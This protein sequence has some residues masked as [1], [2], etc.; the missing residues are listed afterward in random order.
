VRWGKKIFGASVPVEVFSKKTG[1]D[2]GIG[3]WYNG[4][5]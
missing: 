5:E 3:T 1:I 2:E 4:K